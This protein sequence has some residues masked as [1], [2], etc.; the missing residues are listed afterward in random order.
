MAVIA[1]EQHI[2]HTVVINVC[3]MSQNLTDCH[4]VGTVSSDWFCTYFTHSAAVFFIE[5][6]ES[7]M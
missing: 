3:R 2:S 1:K 7:V 4:V 5:F 6:G